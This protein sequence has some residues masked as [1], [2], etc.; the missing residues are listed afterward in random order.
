MEGIMSAISDRFV[1]NLSTAFVKRIF[2]NLIFRLLLPVAQISFQSHFTR[3]CLARRLSVQK[4][5]RSLINL[6]TTNVNH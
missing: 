1:Y 3:I 6:L 4:G 2:E 5:R